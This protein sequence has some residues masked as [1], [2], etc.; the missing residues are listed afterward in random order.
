MAVLSIL[1]LT[2]EV[3]DPDPDEILTDVVVLMRTVRTAEDGRLY[4]AVTIGCTPTTTGMVQR[5]M[6]EVANQ[7][8]RGAWAKRGGDE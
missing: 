2:L 3:E 6:L 5:G 4:D 7:I 1:G 8:S